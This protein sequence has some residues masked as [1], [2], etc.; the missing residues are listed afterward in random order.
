MS[1]NVLTTRNYNLEIRADNTESGIIEGVPIVFERETIINDW[2]GQFKEIVDRNALRKTDL[3]DVRLFVNHDTNKITLA[4]SKNGKGTMQLFVEDD[5]LHMKAELDIENNVEAKSLYSA[6]KRGDMDGMSFMFRVDGEEWSD[7]DK[8]VPTRRI[9][10]ISIVHEVSVVNFPAYQQTSVNA[11]SAEETK[12][13]VLEE[14]RK[15]YSEETE[16]IKQKELELE[17][18]KY[19]YLLH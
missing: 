14:A 9:T 17:K 1:K 2:A 5:G 13:S 10:S 16:Q 19:S 3:K 12:T 18:L 15:R 8:D 11:R 6:V 7:L 4:R